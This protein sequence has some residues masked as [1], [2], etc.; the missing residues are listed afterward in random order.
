M[1]MKMPQNRMAS[2]ET[3]EAP[4]QVQTPAPQTTK[5][6]C[7]YCGSRK[8]RVVGTKGAHRN[9]HCEGCGRPFTTFEAVKK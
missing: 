5:P 3:R 8:S 9:R 1:K 2:P 7:P 4:V 6:A